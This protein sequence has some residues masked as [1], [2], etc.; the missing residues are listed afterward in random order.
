MLHKVG[1][2]HC[3]TTDELQRSYPLTE[4]FSLESHRVNRTCTLSLLHCPTEHEEEQQPVCLPVKPQNSTPGIYRLGI[5]CM[6]CRV[7]LL[8]LAM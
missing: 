4:A 1:Q 6:G 8:P 7:S 2:L 5:C 3:L